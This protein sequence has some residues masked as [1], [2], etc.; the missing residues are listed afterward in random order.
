MPINLPEEAA[1]WPNKNVPSGLPGNVLWRVFQSGLNRLCKQYLV[2]RG[3]V[4]AESAVQVEQND[5]YAVRGD[6][7]A[8]ASTE[9][10]GR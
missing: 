6:Q 5:A 9:L 10:P 4:V 1:N 3:A 8:N 2:G 7:V